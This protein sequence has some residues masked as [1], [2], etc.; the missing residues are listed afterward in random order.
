MS[1]ILFSVNIAY[2]FI[3]IKNI[4]EDYVDSRHLGRYLVDKQRINIKLQQNARVETLTFKWRT[5][6][7]FCFSFFKIAL[8]K[9]SLKS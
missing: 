7:S 5:Y 6:G 4:F 9:F 3:K 1:F 2:L 8:A